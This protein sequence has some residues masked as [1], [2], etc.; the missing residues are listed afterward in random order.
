MRD[1][2]VGYF[3]DSLVGEVE[4]GEYSVTGEVQGSEIYLVNL[5]WKNDGSG[6][7]FGNC[8]CPHSREGNFCKHL[9]AFILEIDDTKGPPANFPQ[10]LLKLNFGSSVTLQKPHSPTPATS[11]RKV[12]GQRP[13]GK[14]KSAWQTN[15]EVFVV[16][17]PSTVAEGAVDFKFFAAEKST[18]NIL[19]FPRPLSLPQNGDIHHPDLQFQASLTAI[20]TLALGESAWH[21]G[22]V[23][24]RYYS[25]PSVR[26]LK[27][28]SL[29]F[30]LRNLLESSRVFA[31]KEDFVKSQRG[32][33]NNFLKPIQFGSMKLVV[34]DQEIGHLLSASVEVQINS[35]RG[36]TDSN[37]LVPLSEL[38]ALAAPNLFRFQNGVGFFDLSETEQMWFADLSAGE[39]RIPP[40]DAEPFLET[41]LNES[42][43]VE[44]PRSL[45]WELVKLA[46]A[47]KIDLTVDKDTGLDRYKV[48]L[49]FQYGSRYA[50]YWNLN[51]LLPSAEDKR[52]YQRDQKEEDRVFT[53]LPLE[54]LSQRRETDAPT[55]HAKNLVDFVKRALSVGLQVNIDS[56]KISEATDFKIE[57]TSGLDW[58]DVDGEA[59]FSGRWVKYPSILEAVSRGEKFIPL[60]DGSVGL[61]SDAMIKRLEKLASFA[62][63]TSDGLRFTGAQ[64]LLLNSLLENEQILKLDEKFKV[65]REKIKQFSGIHPVDPVSSFKGKLRKYQREGLAWLEF[66]E[67][68][69]LGGI[70]A[71]DM[72]LGKTIQ[73]LAFLANRHRR[74]KKVGPSLLLA[75]KSLLENWRME[76]ARFTPDLRVLVHAGSEREI[77]ESAFKQ[78]DL[79]VTTYQTLLRDLDLMQKIEWNCLLADEAQAIKNPEALISRA[80]KLLPAKFRLAMTG[81]PIENSIQDLFSISDFVNPGFL[82]GKRRNAHLKIADDVRQVLAAAFKP[83]VLRRTKEQVLKDLPA[84]TEQLIKVDLE[85]KQ[86]KIYNEMKRYYQGQLLQEVKEHGVKKSQIQIL[87]ALTRLRQV[88]L[89]PGLVDP[90]HANLKSSKF[91]VVLE[92]LTEIVL[93]GHRVLVFSQFTSLLALLKKELNQRKIEFCYL[94]GQTI[95]RQQVVDSFKRSSQPVFLM[96]LK[97][98]GVGLNLV[99]ADY[100]FLLDPWWNPA[101]EAQAIDRVH[102]IGQT[103]PVNAYRFIAKGTVEEKILN[104]QNTKRGISEE[105]LGKKSGSL[106]DLTAQDIEQLFA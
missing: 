15:A 58:F 18:A 25:D 14:S 4:F 54:L 2:G 60:P 64:G 75:P 95:K 53:S 11:W 17:E 104:L 36:L 62:E 37:L 46:P 29:R 61:V 30:L 67:S 5:T 99:E 40:E 7:I 24:Y 93:E 50:S 66:L 41:L 33:Q 65:L 26:T 89:H 45:S 12:F 16:L 82:T 21:G 13:K 49:R 71:D 88:A 101:V 39:L 69:G 83:V 35:E 73:C 70:L 6:A 19:S 77:S 79:V 47:V 43:R 86:L 63:K 98:G 22:Y 23:S 20:A 52:I 105:I 84:K 9:W 78:Q 55:V 96:S 56:K 3:Y 57:V 72:G 100:V 28:S 51:K 102:R 34:M 1:R 59:S 80:V 27:A 8:T 44:L 91:E 85:P 97:A 92:M 76:A 94:D 74:L 31:S 87:A 38:R 68:F 90:G 10:G 32:D 48:D 106:R 42:I 81:T 103:R